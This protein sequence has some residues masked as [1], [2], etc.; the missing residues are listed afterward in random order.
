MTK[1]LKGKFDLGIKLI[2]VW[3]PCIKQWGAGEVF[4]RSRPQAG[5]T[6]RMTRFTVNSHQRPFGVSCLSKLSGTVSTPPSIKIRSYGPSSGYPSTKRDF[7]IAALSIPIETN[8]SCAFSTRFARVSMAITDPANFAA[9]AV[10]Y[11]QPAPTIKRL[12]SGPYL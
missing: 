3:H 1:A 9:T 10:P 11:P 8:T 5:H 4:T 6:H 7:T 2:K 12:S